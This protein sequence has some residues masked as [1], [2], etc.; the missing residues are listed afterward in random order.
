MIASV[1]TLRH[2]GHPVAHSMVMDYV[3]CMTQTALE[4]EDKKPAG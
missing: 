2:V 1:A 4:V 3:G